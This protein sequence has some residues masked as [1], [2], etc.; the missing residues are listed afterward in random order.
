MNSNDIT[1]VGFL[2]TSII[3]NSNGNSVSIDDYLKV[4]EGIMDENNSLGTA[5]QIL[6]TI[7]NGVD[8]GVRWIDAPG[9]YTFSAGTNMQVSQTGNSVQYY[10]NANPGVNMASYPITNATTISAPTGGNISVRAS[11]NNFSYLT[12]SD[13]STPLIAAGKGGI[14]LNPWDGGSGTVSGVSINSSTTTIS[15]IL[16]VMYSI[17][18]NLGQEGTLGQVLSSQGAGQPV[19]WKTLPSY[20]STLGLLG[21]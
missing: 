8:K 11:G 21:V 12:N 15:N 20:S 9:A 3:T 6:S 5:G 19:T 2:D 10:F 14:S 7:Y 18:N 1:N 4:P 16:K 13:L 17:Q